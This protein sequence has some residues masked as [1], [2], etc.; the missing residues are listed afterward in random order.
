MFKKI[1]ISLSMVF[2]AF[3]TGY[4]TAQSF[5]LN[6]TP[7]MAAN[8]SSASTSAAPQGL[9]PASASEFQSKN[10]QL[11]KQKND[12]LD[13]QLKQNLSKIPPTP[14][15]TIPSKPSNNDIGTATPEISKAYP[16]TDKNAAN[17][18]TPDQPQPAATPTGPTPVAPT[19]PA[20][21]DVYTGFQND[22]NNNQAKQPGNSGSGSGW[23]IKY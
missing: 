8:N 12:A 16:D 14:A 7:D 11:K 21:N 23:N 10:E 18:I 22:Q 4:A 20:Q 19:A 17:T 15:P 1:F 3:M 2:I 13:S 6:K 5:F 9:H